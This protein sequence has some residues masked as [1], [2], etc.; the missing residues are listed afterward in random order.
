MLYQTCVDDNLMAT[1]DFRCLLL[2]HLFK[3]GLSFQIYGIL[4]FDGFASHPGGI[5]PIKLEFCGFI[6][7]HE[8][9][10]RI[11]K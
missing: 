1:G 2:C 10:E 7:S 4:S 5:T 8:S 9:V 11:D 3:G 6:S